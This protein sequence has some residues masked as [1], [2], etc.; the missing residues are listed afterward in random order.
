MSTPPPFR[1]T[2]VSVL[3][4]VF[5][6]LAGFTTLIATL[7]NLLLQWLFL[8]LMSQAQP[9]MPAGMP[10]PLRFM[11]GH[12]AW[13]FRAFLLL[14]VLTLTAAIG[15][16]RRQEWARRL[17]IGL[18]GFGIAYQVLGVAFQWWFMGSMTGFMHDPHAPAQFDSVMRDVLLMVRVFSALFAAGIVVL[19]G[20]IIRRLCSAAVREEFGAAPR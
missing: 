19:F 15:L 11:A 13:F 14:S 3:A 17:F 16:L 4:W 2:F 7:Q 5:I 8:P 18:L 20:W 1:S 6:G 12:F 9:P 10:L